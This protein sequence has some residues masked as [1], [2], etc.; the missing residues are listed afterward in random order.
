MTEKKGKLNE[1]GSVFAII[2]WIVVIIVLAVGGVLLAIN[3]GWWKNPPEAITSLPFME[4]ILPKEKTE[5]TEPVEI[6]EVD[7]LR[8]QVLQLRRDYVAAEATI[9]SQMQE[10]A[11]K[12]RTITERDDEI[13]RLRN[14]V[15]LARDQNIQAAALIH[16]NMD[17]EESAIILSKL[18]ADEASLILGAM[19]ESKA[20]DV[21]AKMDEDLATQITEI[22][23]GFRS[24]P[25]GTTS[26]ELTP[27][28]S[29]TAPPTE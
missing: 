10:I 9:E 26:P 22:L 16:E 3:Q 21:L 25:A 13:A 24:P 12:D 28:A 15:N 5:S 8:A 27:P 1:S 7:N 14:T 17:P 29:E 19:R 4:S 18:G 6:S 11:E 23:A 2:L 20:A